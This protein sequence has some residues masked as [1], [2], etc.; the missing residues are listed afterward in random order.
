MAYTFQTFSLGNVL[1]AAQLNQIEVNIRDHV[2]GDDGVAQ[3]DLRAAPF[4]SDQQSLASGVGRSLTL[5]HGLGRQPR[6]TEMS[7]LCTSTDGAWVAGDEVDV[8]FASQNGVAAYVSSGDVTN[9]H[10]LVS[11]NT[12]QFQLPRP[13]TQVNDNLNPS[14]WKLIV[15]CW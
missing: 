15:R 3:S 4:V 7:I 14:R 1:T 10:V 8:K 9:V 13:D 12:P 5:A 2:H 6:Q 11:T